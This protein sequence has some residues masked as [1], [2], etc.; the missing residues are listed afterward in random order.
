MK[1]G[2]GQVSRQHQFFLRAHSRAFAAK[3]ERKDGTGKGV[4]QESHHL[5]KI[6]SD[7]IKALFNENL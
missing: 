6:I 7:N 5:E 3:P 2:A 4:R 1:P